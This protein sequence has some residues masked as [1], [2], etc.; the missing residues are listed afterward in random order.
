MSDVFIIH[1]IDCP[2]SG[3]NVSPDNMYTYLH[4]YPRSLDRSIPATRLLHNKLGRMI[5]VQHTG[6][7][8]LARSRADKVNLQSR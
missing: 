3:I 1:T 6:V 5:F 2:S 7:Q 8:S 4:S